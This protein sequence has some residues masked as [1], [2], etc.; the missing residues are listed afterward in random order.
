MEGAGKGRGGQAF[1][2]LKKRLRWLGDVTLGHQINHFEQ[3][4]FKL[5]NSFFLSL[6]PQIGL[7]KKE[8]ENSL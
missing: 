5:K 4:L 8:D 6:G 3:H 2:G 1:W 7:L